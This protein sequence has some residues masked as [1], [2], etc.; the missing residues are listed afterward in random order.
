VDLIA[1][2]AIG[3]WGGGIDVGCGFFATIWLFLLLLVL[4]VP[5]LPPFEAIGA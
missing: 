3:S 4:V 2:A 5:F 1:D